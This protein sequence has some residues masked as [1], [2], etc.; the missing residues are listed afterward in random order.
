MYFLA[1]RDTNTTTANGGNDSPQQAVE[2]LFTTLGNSDPIGVADQLDPAEAALFT[3]LNT[4][5][6]TEL[7][8]LDVLSDAARRIR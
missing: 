1:I 3:D 8:R 4:D 7:K 5:V 2:S 6:I